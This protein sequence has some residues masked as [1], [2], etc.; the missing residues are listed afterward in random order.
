MT[1]PGRAGARAVVVGAGIGGLAAAAALAPVFDAVKIF[2]KDELPD[3]PRPR[4]GVPQDL[5]VHIL[6]KGGERSLESLLPGTRAALL[7]AGAI[8]VQQTRDVAIWERDAWQ[9]TRDLG[10][11]QLMMSRPALE[12]VVRQ[13][14]LKLGNV[15]IRDRCPVDAVPSG[16]DLTVIAS[17]RG[18]KLLAGLEVPETVLG[19]EV[20]YSSARF[21]K[22]ARFRGEGRFIACIPKPPDD[23]Y[24]L[25]CPVENDEWLITLCGRFDNRVPDDPEGFRAYAATLP[26][27]DI[28]ERLRDAVPLTPVR[29]YRLAEARW[30]HYERAGGLPPRVLPIGDCISN[31]NPTFGQGMSVAAGHAVALRDVLAETSDLDAV[32]DAYL[33]RAAEVSRQAWSLTAMADLEY[34]RTVGERPARFDQMVLG[35]EAMRRAA[36]LHPEVHLLRF[37]I[38]NLLKPDSA[39]RSGPAARLVVREMAR[40]GR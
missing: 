16:A 12:L 39:A 2:D 10:Y 33:P 5:Q 17:G 11:S 28:A 14:V 35:S 32:A 24:G 21:A 38:G 40:A 6:L 26:V 13:Q 1:R 27:P 36:V 23:R 3:S 4:K 25:V 8:E 31:F 34:P 22:P 18:D 20:N 29:R 9:A 15:A 7:R 19:L 37:E 30:R